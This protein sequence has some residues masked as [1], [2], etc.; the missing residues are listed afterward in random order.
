VAPG[1]RDFAVRASV[2]RPALEQSL[3]GDRPA[4]IHARNANRVHRIPKSSV[5][6]DAY[7]PHQDRNAP[8]I[9]LILVLREAIYFFRD[10]WTRQISLNWQAKFASARKRFSPAWT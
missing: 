2:A 3:T 6:D 8:T 1:P 5:R 4:I 10:N 9:R 7:A